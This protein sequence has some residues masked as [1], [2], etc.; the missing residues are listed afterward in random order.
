[1]S[2]EWIK[3]SGT[4]QGSDLDTIISSIIKEIDNGLYIAMYTDR[5]ESGKITDDCRFEDKYVLEIRIFNKDKE[6]LLSRGSISEDFIWRYIS[7]DKTLDDESYYARYHVIDMNEPLSKDYLDN[8]NLSIIST[9]GGRY[10]LP[11]TEGTKK[12][13]IITY[14][15]YDEN[16]MA[17]AADN[18]VCGFE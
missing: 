6:I 17:Y 1:M 13:K 3:E 2:K 10:S 14:I 9:G 16:G 4:C 5:F 7:N 11:V 8:G 18:R 15:D 12:I